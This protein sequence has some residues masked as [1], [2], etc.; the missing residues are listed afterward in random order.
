MLRLREVIDAMLAVASYFEATLFEA[1]P[2]KLLRTVMLLGRVGHDKRALNLPPPL[3][4]NVPIKAPLP[5][6]YTRSNAVGS[7]P[8]A[9]TQREW[10]DLVYS[11]R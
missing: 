11:A 7:V 4:V 5:V 8:V 6:T 9:S 3:F 1:K 2:P 10:V